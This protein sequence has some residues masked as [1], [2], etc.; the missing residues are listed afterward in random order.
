MSNSIFLD[1][2]VLVEY[3][4]GT[5]IDLLEAIIL[6][7]DFE[8]VINQVVVSEYLYYHIA[9]FS[10][11]SPMTIK[12]ATDIAKY[13][14]MGDPETFLSQF[15]WLSDFPFVLKKALTLMQTH[16]LLPNDAII[17]ATCLFHGITCIASYDSDY[18][19]ACLAEGIELVDSKAAFLALK[20][21]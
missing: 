5:Q 15:G 21:I 13:L 6:D 11:K 20:R 7:K 19:D 2:S 18:K 9:I 10:G 4:K 14:S 16:N 17:L 12:S 1:S 8:A 3:R